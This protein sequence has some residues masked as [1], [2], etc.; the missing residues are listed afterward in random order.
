MVAGSNLSWQGIKR[1]A[2]YT[3]GAGPVCK[4][5]GQCTLEGSVQYVYRVGDRDWWGRDWKGVYRVGDRDLGCNIFLR[6]WLFCRRRQFAL[7]I[8]FAV[9][10]HVCLYSQICYYRTSDSGVVD[11]ALVLRYHGC[12]FESQLARA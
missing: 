9:I 6:Q 8:Y 4:C 1:K 7:G 12:E 5:M 10:I 2:V 3:E 11:R